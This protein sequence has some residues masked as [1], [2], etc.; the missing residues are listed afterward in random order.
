MEKARYQL[1]DKAPDMTAA[2]LSFEI[3]LGGYESTTSLFWEENETPEDLR[4]AAIV[5]I[6]ANFRCTSLLYTTGKASTKVFLNH[7]LPL[8]KELLPKS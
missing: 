4:D 6:C 2:V 3:C 5:T 8:A 7:L 1:K